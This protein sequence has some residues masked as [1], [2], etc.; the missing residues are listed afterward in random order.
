MA[1]GNGWLAL[2]LPRTVKCYILWFKH[3]A[4]GGHVC[5]VFMQRVSNVMLPRIKLSINIINVGIFLSTIEP[6][7]CHIV[8]AQ[9]YCLMYCI[10]THLVTTSVCVFW[11]YHIFFLNNSVVTLLNFILHHCLSYAKVQE[12]FQ[13]RCLDILLWGHL[14]GQVQIS[15]PQM[16]EETKVNIKTQIAQIMCALLCTGSTNNKKRFQAFTGVGGG[17]FAHML[18][19]SEMIL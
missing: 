8:I 17:H 3:L 1:N 9:T 13:W 11:Q 4:Y 19:S 7:E 15:N 18:Q 5:L 2:H 6:S 16:P 10:N 14:K 12:Q